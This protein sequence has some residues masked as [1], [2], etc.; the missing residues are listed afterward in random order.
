MDISKNMGLWD[1]VARLV[2]GAIL[3]GLAAM[4]TIGIWGWLGLILVGTAFMS[5]CPLYRII[6][7]KTC[8]NC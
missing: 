2:I 5:F 8:Q 4:G 3:V 7:L 1:R 6:G